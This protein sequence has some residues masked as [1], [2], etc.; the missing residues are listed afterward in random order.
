M[1]VLGIWGHYKNSI[2]L[3]QA[4]KNN[5]QKYINKKVFKISFYQL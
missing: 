4:Y 2:P 5:T 3:G 1:P